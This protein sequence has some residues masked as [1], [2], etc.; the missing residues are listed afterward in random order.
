MKK[1]EIQ[2]HKSH[3]HP[4][5]I[6]R[7]TPISP[8]P[9]GLR[10]G[11]TDHRDGAALGPQ[12]YNRW[13]A[14]YNL[15]SNTVNTL[16]VCTADHQSFTNF[17]V[18]NIT[19]PNMT[20]VILTTFGT[21][22]V[23]S[24]LPLSS[25][26]TVTGTALF[27][28]PITVENGGLDA[29]YG[30]QINLQA[31]GFPTSYGSTIKSSASSVARENGVAFAVGA[32][33]DGS[34]QSQVMTLI[35]NGTVGIDTVS[36][37]AA[38]EVNGTGLFDGGIMTHDTN[39]LVAG[40]ATAYSGQFATIASGWTNNTATNAVYLYTGTSGN[41]VLWWCGGTGGASPCANAIIT[42]T[43]A[44]SGGNFPVPQ[45][46]GV[47]ITSGVGLTAVVVFKP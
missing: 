26:L 9:P 23:A 44:A 7:I 6:T 3:E 13:Y 17:G 22:I 34:T 47:Q 45:G 11:D 28:A 35:G 15:G 31:V 33:G 42:D 5:K 14:V 19:I 16:K 32:G 18:T 2:K 10:A 43:V 27:H 25:N 29:S 24:F 39:I 8:I 37:N 1:E 4:K 38:L 21:N 30:S 20:E 46:C 36:P 12:Y 41:A 40:S